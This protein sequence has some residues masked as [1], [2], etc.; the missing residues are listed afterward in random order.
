MTPVQ[1]GCDYVT[2]LLHNVSSSLADNVGNGTVLRF[3]LVVADDV[4][5]DEAVPAQKPFTN[6]TTAGGRNHGPLHSDAYPDT[7][8]PGQ[9]A[10]CSAGNETYS[11]SAAAIGTQ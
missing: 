1:S 7:M 10:I 2:T 5:G 9:P 4:T 8:S 11:A 3:V 6:T